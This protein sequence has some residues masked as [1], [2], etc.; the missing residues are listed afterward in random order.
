MAAKQSWA[1]GLCALAGLAAAAPAE[2]AD[3]TGEAGVTS[4]YRYRGLSLS[5]GKPAAQAQIGAELPS[6]LYA[7][8]WTSTLG[9]DSAEVDATAGYAAD[10][11]SG[12]S[13]DVSATFYAY[14]DSW[15]ANALATN[16]E[17][18]ANRGPVTLTAGASFAPPQ[19]GTRDDAG[20]KTGNFYAYAGASV[21]L[22]ERVTVR[23]QLGRER[24]AWDMRLA[25]AKW[26]WD[27]GLD[28]ELER[29]RFSLE[30][31]GSNAAGDG[32]VASAFLKF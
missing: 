10:L 18:G 31:V 15:S 5:D 29:V 12:L 1:A 32:L 26:D 25:G 7:T 30:A 4:D 14:P 11:G 22:D 9:G 27:L 17:L 8:L 19:G 21:A 6:G 3:W 28:L 20:R 13:L 2:A 23:A 16:V 24:G